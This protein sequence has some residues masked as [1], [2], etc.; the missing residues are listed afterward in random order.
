M[1]QFHPVEYFSTIDTVYMPNLPTRSDPN[2][3]LLRGLEILRA[4]RPGSDVLGNAEIAERTGLPK[5][6]VSRL[7]GT[8]LKAGFLFYSPQQHGYSLG[9]A[10]LS[11]S[12]AMRSG[13]ILL[14][15]A[16]PIMVAEARRLKINVGIAIADRDEMVYL[17]TLRFS[18]SSS[19]RQVVSGQRVPMALTSLGRAYLSTL[20]LE[21]RRAQLAQ[22][23][24]KHTRDWSALRPEIN[25]S[26]QSVELNGWCAA[27]WQPQVI[28]L[29]TPLP[30][31][32]QAI[33][34]L[35]MSIQTSECI[36]RVVERLGPELIRLKNK[37]IK[38][39]HAHF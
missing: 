20:T 38:A 12:H 8:L 36:E 31:E 14:Q 22:L 3:S 35:N 4:F 30:I 11:L 9:G 39:H 32:P 10:V 34:I 13:S 25:A 15:L 16:R 17:E 26:I 5:S 27:S 7:T 2:R 6:T 23:K 24:S 33:H 29:A 37:L 19:L 21:E 28:A 18:G 1:A